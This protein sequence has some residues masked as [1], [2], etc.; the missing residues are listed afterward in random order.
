MWLVRSDI[1]FPM[2]IKGLADAYPMVAEQAD[3]DRVGVID[4][5]RLD[6]I[7]NGIILCDEPDICHLM[8]SA[9]HYRLRCCGFAAVI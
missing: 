3:I 2:D 5:R 1:S 6:D 8:S 9:G 4:N 7:R